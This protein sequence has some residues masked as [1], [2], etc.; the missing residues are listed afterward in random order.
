MVIYL[1]I[2]VFRLIFL[3]QFVLMSI[4][5]GQ[6]VFAL[7]QAHNTDKGLFIFLVVIT[8][9]LILRFTFDLNSPTV[10]LP[11]LAISGDLFLSF[12]LHLHSPFSSYF[13][14]HLPTTLAHTHTHHILGIWRGFKIKSFRIEKLIVLLCCFIQ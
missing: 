7:R 8:F 13:A 4:F 10:F 14:Y 9:T 12:H 3:S 5:K 2:N 6:Y 1:I 11:S